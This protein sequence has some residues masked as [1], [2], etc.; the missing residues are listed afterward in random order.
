MDSK[1]QMFWFVRKR[2]YFLKIYIFLFLLVGNR[3]WFVNLRDR[4][5]TVEAFTALMK[6]LYKPELVH[7]F[8]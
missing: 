7:L 6:E 1:R 4:T 3:I 8:D 5:R 2:N